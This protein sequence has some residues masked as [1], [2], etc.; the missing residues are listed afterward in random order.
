MRAAGGRVILVNGE[1]YEQFRDLT[2]TGL[3]DRV[4]GE[5]GGVLYRP[6]QQGAEPLG[7]TVPTALVPALL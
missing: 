6:G 1:V 2:E 7:E 3:F 4:V 5:N